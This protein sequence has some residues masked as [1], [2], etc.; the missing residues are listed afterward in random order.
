M[1]P[2]LLL[3][4]FSLPFS[5]SPSV[6]HSLSLS[7]SLSLLLSLS[8]GH[9]T[10][11]LALSLLLQSLLVKAFQAISPKFSLLRVHIITRKCIPDPFSQVR[12]IPILTVPDNTTIGNHKPPPVAPESRSLCAARSLCLVNRLEFLSWP[13]IFLF[14]CVFFFF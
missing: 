12:T 2:S 13:G 1:A 8:L 11:P 7:L 6:S 14:L 10:V 3:Q 9:L 5:Y 4:S